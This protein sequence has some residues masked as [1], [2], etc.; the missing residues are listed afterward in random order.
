MSLKIGWRGKKSACV[1]LISSGM[2]NTETFLQFALCLPVESL[3]RLSD[4]C[5]FSLGLDLLTNSFE[6][7][8]AMD[9]ESAKEPCSPTISPGNVRLHVPGD[10]VDRTSDFLN[11]KG[12]SPEGLGYPPVRI[13]T[14]E[15][16][17]N[18][19]GRHL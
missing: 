14:K 10:V 9:A 12:A 13:F 19:Y 1:F 15:V 4:F 6:S 11:H 8:K 17:K 5:F 7:L 18:G 16:T 2:R 3:R